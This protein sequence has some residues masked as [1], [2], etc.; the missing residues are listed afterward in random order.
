M[1]NDLSE[2]ILV[3]H[4]SLAAEAERCTSSLGAA[5]PIRLQYL[6]KA[7]PT[8]PPKV[9]LP[10]LLHTEG[11]GGQQLSYKHSCIQPIQSPSR[12]WR[13]PSLP[14]NAASFLGE[15]MIGSSFVE[16]ATLA[17]ILSST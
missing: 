8:L 7:Y 10:L 3:E 2:L 9:R 11:N 6:C 13:R 12:G 14:L 1:I 17:A 4:E 16:I 5:D 15:F